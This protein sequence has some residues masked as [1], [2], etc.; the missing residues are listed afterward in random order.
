MHNFGR[1]CALYSMSFPRTYYI[2]HESK[3]G[4]FCSVGAILNHERRKHILELNKGKRTKNKQK[5]GGKC[6][7]GTASPSGNK[8]FMAQSG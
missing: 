2:A 5:Y 7:V 4:L 3:S 8:D 1:V 6:K